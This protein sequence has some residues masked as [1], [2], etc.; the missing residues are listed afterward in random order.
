M[1]TNFNFQEYSTWPEVPMIFQKTWIFPKYTIAV[2]VKRVIVFAMLYLK[3][4]PGTT[5]CP[6]VHPDRRSTKTKT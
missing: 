5:R 1:L 4:T 6:F 2:A 3:T